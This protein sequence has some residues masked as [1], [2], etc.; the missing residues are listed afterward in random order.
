[1][2][3]MELHETQASTD[4]PSGA[5]TAPSA[6]NHLEPSVGQQLRHARESA[7]MSID[8]LSVQLKVSVRNLESIEADAWDKLPDFVYTRALIAS[9][10]RH[11]KLDT[12]PLL[13]KVPMPAGTTRL[14]PQPAV[15]LS[16]TGLPLPKVTSVM[17][18]TRGWAWVVLAATLGA[19]ALWSQQN[20]WMFDRAVEQVQR[21]TTAN[22][23]RVSAST[24][25]EPAIPPASQAPVGTAPGTEWPPGNAA[26]A[27]LPAGHVV[28][29]VSPGGR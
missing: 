19:A 7:G 26:P 29:E 27:P 3:G 1:M 5:L 20:L 17:R 14:L 28:Q 18:R 10:C 12:R 16:K 13:Q 15:D 24:P 21:W 2:Q 9:I 8:A 22:D 4:I 23:T 11:L 25:V 6:Q